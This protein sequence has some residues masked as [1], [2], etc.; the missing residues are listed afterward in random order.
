M[1]AIY[2]NPNITDK[3][4]VDKIKKFANEYTEY[5]NKLSVSLFL[6]VS[7]RKDNYLDMINQQNSLDDFSDDYKTLTEKEIIESAK[8]ASPKYI[9]TSK[10]VIESISKMF[11]LPNDFFL[12]DLP[13]HIENIHYNVL[14][15]FW[16]CRLSLSIPAIKGHLDLIIAEMKRHGYYLVATKTRDV[17]TNP[18]FELVFNPIY[19][20]SIR[21]MLN[22]KKA[23]VFHYS[24]DFNDETI[25]EHGLVPKDG[26]RIFKYKHRIYFV[27]SEAINSKKFRHMMRSITRQIKDK[28][29]DWSGHFTEYEFRVKSLPDDIEFYWDPNA[30]HSVYVTK[31]IAAKYIRYIEHN[32]SFID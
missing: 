28:K 21:E 22:D 16:K 32:V 9:E 27:L 29:E 30:A 10:E 18:W 7:K 31:P 17:E 1:S 24:P 20:E 2:I 5:L 11:K 14:P 19:Q 13:N 3:E 15:S 26:K 23:I 8:N 25:E 12:V 6:E 4:E